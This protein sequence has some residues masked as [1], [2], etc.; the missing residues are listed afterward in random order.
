MPRNPHNK[1]VGQ[2]EYQ[3]IIDAHWVSAHLDIENAHDFA[4]DKNGIVLM[5]TDHPTRAVIEFSSDGEVLKEWGYFPGAHGIEISQENGEEFIYIVDSGWIINP[6][7]DGISTDAWD[8]PYNKVVPQSGSIWKLTRMG[9]IVWTLGHPQTLGL[10]QPEMPFNPTDIAITSDG[11]LYVTD[12][13]GS[14]FVLHLSRDGQVKSMWG[15]HN[16]EDPNH[17]IHNAHGITFDGRGDVPRLIISSRSEQELK[18]YT[19]DGNYLSSITTPG[20]YIHAPVIADFGMVAAVCWTGSKA[21]PEEN[22]GVVCVFDNSDELV[23]VLGGTNAHQIH[24]DGETFHH[25]HGIAVQQNGDILVAQWRGEHTM[26][27]KLSK[28]K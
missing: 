17:N 1:I 18:C 16:N 11:D 12:G 2:G 8:S 5:V 28:A 7:W 15:G 25:C 3:Y 21:A 23:S 27:F 14:D 22:S 24:S 6:D 4:I 9:R 20:A 26:P 10:Y 13:Y 19:L